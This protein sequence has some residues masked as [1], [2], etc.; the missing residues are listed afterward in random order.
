MYLG[1]EAFGA[2]NVS[3]RYLQAPDSSLGPERAQ[4]GQDAAPGELAACLCHLPLAEGQ[5][6]LTTG[7]GLA[8]QDS[9]RGYQGLCKFSGTLNCPFCAV[10]PVLSSF[11]FGRGEK[12]DLSGRE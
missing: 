3:T 2:H 8:L 1:T 4:A 7:S 5:A 9:S 11:A 10:T 6:A 12:G